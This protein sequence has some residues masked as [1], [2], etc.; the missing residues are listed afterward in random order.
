LEADNNFQVRRL[1][2]SQ[3]DGKLQVDPDKPLKADELEDEITKLFLPKDDR[4]TA[5]LFFAGHGLP[6][7]LG[8]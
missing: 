8:I 3:I 2:C 5:L 7:P 1:P 4:D 6:K